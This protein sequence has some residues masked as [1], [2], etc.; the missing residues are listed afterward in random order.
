MYTR[1]ENLKIFKRIGVTKEVYGILRN[2]KMESI[3]K[4]SKI[5]MAKII[6]NLVLENYGNETVPKVWPEK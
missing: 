2:K 5:S 3:K 6:C 1:E 4:K